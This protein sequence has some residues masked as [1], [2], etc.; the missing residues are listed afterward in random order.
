M[1]V[2]RDGY[3]K[4]RMEEF[5]PDPV[6]MPKNGDVEEG[7]TGGRQ[8]RDEKRGDYGRLQQKTKGK[9]VHNGS[10]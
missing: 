9:N 6:H 7:R 4:A 5:A 3:E 2:L 10:K 8:V 1:I